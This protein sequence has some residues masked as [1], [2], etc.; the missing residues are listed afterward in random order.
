MGWGKFQIP[1]RNLISF[2]T[3]T[4]VTRKG[5]LSILELQV[6]Y[7]W[8][9]LVVTRK[10]SRVTEYKDHGLFDCSVPNAGSVGLTAG[11]A[12]PLVD[13]RSPVFG[14]TDSSGCD[15]AS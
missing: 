8:A 6:K 4:E 9:A 14:R 10:E 11:D 15:L 12:S 1:L 7:P 13:I 3:H 5:S 2:R